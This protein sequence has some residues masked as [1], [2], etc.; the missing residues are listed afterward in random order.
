MKRPIQGRSANSFLTAQNSSCTEN[1][2]PRGDRRGD[3]LDEVRGVRRARRELGPGGVRVS[4]GRK[5]RRPRR[6]DFDDRPE[7]DSTSIGKTAVRGVLVQS[8]QRDVGTL[9]VSRDFPTPASPT[10]ASSRSRRSAPGGIRTAS[11]KEPGARRRARQ[12]S[13]TRRKRPSRS[14][15]T[16]SRRYAGTPFRFALSSSGSISST[17]TASR[18]KR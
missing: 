13:L 14:S 3:A 18:V 17:S 10:S 9:A 15:L 4:C 1:C 11:R 12:A 7:S 16:D 6:N 5:S 2:V 8:R